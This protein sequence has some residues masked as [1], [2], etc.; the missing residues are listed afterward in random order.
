MN[1]IDLIRRICLLYGIGFYVTGCGMAAQELTSV[2][3]ILG[4]KLTE[5][6]YSKKVTEKTKD[7]FLTLRQN[8]IINLIIN[9]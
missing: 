8:L 7:R 2:R 9:V 3:F 5:I 4:E 1:I 6:A